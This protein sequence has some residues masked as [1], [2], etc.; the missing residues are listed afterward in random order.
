[1]IISI[2]APLLFLIVIVAY[3]ALVIKWICCIVGQRRKIVEESNEFMVA[4]AR[5]QE[6]A[7]KLSAAQT[8]YYASGE[9]IMVDAT[10]DRLIHELRDLEDTFPQL[11]SVDSP[12]MRVGAKPTKD[13]TNSVRHRQRMYSLQDVFSREELKTWFER[14]QGQI[15]TD[16]EFTAEVKIDGVAINLTYRNG[17]LDTATTRGDGVAGED[18][19]RN[20]LAI[21]AIPQKLKGTDFPELV[22]IRGEVFF[23]VVAF[24]EFNERV[25]QRNDLIVKRNREIAEYNRQIQQENKELK[26]KNKDLPPEQ[27]LALKPLKRRENKLK[28]F[29]N[30]RNAAS[31]SLRQDDNTG[32]A[33]R[34]LSFIAHGLGAVE[35]ASA[36]VENSL[37]QQ[38]KIYELF[39]SWGVPVSSEVTTVKTLP[40]MESYLARYEHR[41]DALAYEFD[42]VVIKVADRG[43]QEKLGFTSR[44]P[45][46]AVAY[47][48]PPTEV[49][50]KLLDIRVQV[51][52]TGRVTPY[53]IMEPV[54]VDGSTVSQATLHNASEVARKNVL[55]GDVVIVRKAG[56]IIPE[57]VAPVLNERD[58]SEYPFVMPKSCPSCG[59]DIAPVKAQDI[60]LRCQ[61]VR[62]CPAQLV[63]R[64][65][66][67]ASRGALDIE[68]FGDDTALW[69]ADPDRYRK[70]ALIALA[71]GAEISFE[72]Q[73]GESVTLQF[74]FIQRQKLGIV[75]ADG[76]FVAGEDIISWDLQHKLEIPSPQQAVLNSEADLFAFTPD[77]AR[78]VWQWQE[79]RKAGVP[80]GNYAY[81]RAAW[82]QPKRGASSLFTIAGEIK[83]PSVPTKNLLKV[84]AE[85]ELAKQKELW[86]KLVALN[87][88]YVGPVAA[89]ALARHFGSLAG[90][91]NASLEEISAVDGVGETIAQ[92]LL[93]WFAVDWHAEIISA[94]EAAGVVFAD[95]ANTD[96]TDLT[97]TLAG[98]AIV[99]TGTL[100]NYRREEIKELVEKRGGKLTSAISAKTTALLAGE[101]A[102]SKLLKA[103]SLGVPV[104]DEDTFMQ[105]L[106]SGELPTK[107]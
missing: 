54:L 100:Q 72:N 35:G 47:K 60:D 97:Q 65:V 1:M 56:D 24:K 45:K 39:K 38:A 8:A 12:S 98:M 28:T 36:V 85:L 66:H 20:A 32:F 26:R 14:V 63:Q 61:N 55:I 25:A 62:S 3:L 57:I 103:Q 84:V 82:T 6:L 17:I 21:S 2:N 29:V 15:S 33:I 27:R 105:F 89:K 51:G 13:G 53:A 76:S 52:R 74:D 73:S 43:E 77:Q 42:G 81:T 92:S 96:I 106:E 30:P 22:E 10:Y 46:W 83:E 40:E 34:S 69:L 90:I 5:W 107:N 70:D 95:E 86:R 9:P 67:I 88:R 23:P 78:N 75:N 91:R 102:G 87:I 48:F 37:S 31:G 11:W 94:W 101:K 104:L 7:A 19:T 64:L 79:I 71:T 59:G 58:G 41:R 93:S 68:A 50:T 16:A 49:Q 18:I 99:C 4:K 44:T 80:T